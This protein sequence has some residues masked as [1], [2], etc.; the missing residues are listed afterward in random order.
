MSDTLPTPDERAKVLIEYQYRGLGVGMPDYCW[1]CSEKA[2]AAAIRE[3]VNAALE[4]AALKL[5]SLAQ[6]TVGGVCDGLSEAADVCRSLKATSE[7]T[8]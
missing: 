3:A 7:P 5:E 1:D 4:S 2:F 6:D 8:P